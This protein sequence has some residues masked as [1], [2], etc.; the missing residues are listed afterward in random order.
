MN[1]E[2]EI[3]APAYIREGGELVV[4]AYKIGYLNGQ[5][6]HIEREIKKTNSE[7]HYIGTVAVTWLAFSGA[8]FWVFL[9]FERWIK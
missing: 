8:C 6:S 2:A 4:S 5:I 1:D 9:I 7:W 3:E